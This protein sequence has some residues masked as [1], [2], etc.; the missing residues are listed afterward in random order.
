ML[1][2]MHNISDASHNMLFR[3]DENYV[4]LQYRRLI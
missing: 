3:D 2:E 4:G 1:A